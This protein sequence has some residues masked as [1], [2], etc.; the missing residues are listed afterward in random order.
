[1]VYAMPTPKIGTEVVSSFT[2]LIDAVK[3]RKLLRPRSKLAMKLAGG[4]FGVNLL[5]NGLIE[6]DGKVPPIAVEKEIENA[7]QHYGAVLEEVR[8]S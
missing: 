4:E 8:V 1:M 5:S 7:M 6:L 3:R 2:S